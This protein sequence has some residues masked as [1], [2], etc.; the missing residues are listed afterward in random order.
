MITII[1]VCRSLGITPEKNLTWAV[2]NKV[3]DLYVHKFGS[4]P[5]KKLLPKTNGQGSHFIAVYPDK[6]WSD[7]ERIIRETDYE[8]PPTLDDL[9]G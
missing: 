6:L 5:T 1:D 8:K 7:I 4:S 9:L 3:R 2:G